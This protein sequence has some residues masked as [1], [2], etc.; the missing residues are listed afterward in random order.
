MITQISPTE[1]DVSETMC[2]LQFASR[3]KGV[4]LGAAKKHRSSKGNKAEEMQLKQDLSCMESEHTA[5]SAVIARQSSELAAAES[6]LADMAAQQATKIS[7]FSSR[8]SELEA[9]LQAVGEEVSINGNHLHC[10]KRMR[11]YQRNCRRKDQ[12][13]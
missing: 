4:E 1:N 9:K 6:S 11:L 2:T 3:V 12:S 8:V 10:H 13:R 5:L 7:G